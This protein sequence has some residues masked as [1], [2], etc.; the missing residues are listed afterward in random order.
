[1]SFKR[2]GKMKF[3]D[4]IIIFFGCKMGKTLSKVIDLSHVTEDAE[5]SPEKITGVKDEK[6]E[7]NPGLTA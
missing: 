7:K 5:A 2:M 1:M 6:E 3:E 4:C